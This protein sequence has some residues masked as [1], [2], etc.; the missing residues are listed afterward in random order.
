MKAVAAA[1]VQHN[2]EKSRVWAAVT[3]ASLTK[4]LRRYNITLTGDF[5]IGGLNGLLPGAAR[6]RGG[7]WDGN[8]TQARKTSRRKEGGA[9]VTR[10][11]G[12]K[13]RR[14]RSD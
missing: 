7:G 3:N 14:C 11:P 1:F 10:G 2:V 12:K 4:K 5:Q 13:G 9:G 8:A 6:E